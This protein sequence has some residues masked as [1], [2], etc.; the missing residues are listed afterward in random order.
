MSDHIP[1]PGQHR[2]LFYAEYANRTRGARQRVESGLPE[3]PA[4]PPRLLPLRPEDEDDRLPDRSALDP[5]TPRP[6]RPEHAAAGQAPARPPGDPPGRR[7]RRG[8]GC[9]GKLGVSATLLR[10]T[11][12][13]SGRSLPAQRRPAGEPIARRLRDQPRRPCATFP[14]LRSSPRRCPCR[15]PC[16]PQAP[17]PAGRETKHLSVRTVLQ[18]T[19]PNRSQVGS[20]RRSNLRLR[21]LC[22]ENQ[23]Y[24]RVVGLGSAG[25]GG[26][27]P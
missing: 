17:D 1:D 9:A 8:L 4:E 11:D 27:L 2:T 20:L 25:T 16:V 5:E 21:R 3:L 15:P 26:S 14:R 19:L 23:P 13:S 12:P 10:H 24:R 6:P 7:A 22:N 18:F